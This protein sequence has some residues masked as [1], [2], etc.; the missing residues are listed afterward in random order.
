MSIDKLKLSDGFVIQ[1]DGSLT[2]CIRY[3]R[4][5]GTEMEAVIMEDFHYE[6]SSVLTLEDFVKERKIKA[7]HKC[8]DAVLKD[9]YGS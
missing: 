6:W 4:A 9:H 2:A 5:D 8:L 7:L 3:K 1:D